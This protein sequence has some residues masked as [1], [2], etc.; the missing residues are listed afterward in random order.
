MKEFLLNLVHSRKFMITASAVVIVAVGAGIGYFAWSTTHPKTEVATKEVK[1]EE[2][3]S[4][5]EV[6]TF[7]DCSIE[8]ESIEKDL[9]LT[10]KDAAGEVVT[11]VDYEVK[12]VSSEL[13]DEINDAVAAIAEVDAKITEATAAADGTTE[14]G[15]EDAAGG[16]DAASVGGSVTTRKVVASGVMTVSAASNT[17]DAATKASESTDATTE[18]KATDAAGETKKADDASEEVSSITGEPLTELEE[19]AIEKQEAIDAYK[20]VLDG[21]DA[22]TY[23][24]DDVDGTIY[25]EEID[26]GDYLACYI[27]TEDNDYSATNYAV[28]VNVKDHVE[29]VAVSN[30]KTVSAAAAGDTQSA[31]KNVPVEATPTNTVSYVESRTETK[32]AEYAQTTTPSVSAEVGSA[33]TTSSTDGSTVITLSQSA[34]LY[35]TVSGANTA[36]ITAS[37]SALPSG[38]S[39]SV[40]SNSPAVSV[41]PAGGDSYTIAAGDVASNSV[42]TISATTTAA[43]GNAVTATCSV[44]ITGADETITNASGQTLYTD[45]NGTVATYRN[46]NANSTYYVMTK[47]AETV[48]YGWQKIGN[49]QYYFDQNGNKVTGTQV[50]NGATYN[51]GSDGVLLT[52]GFGIDVSKWQGN[53][54]WSQASS[55]ISFAIIRVGF[56]GSSGNIAVDPKFERNISQA[57]ANGVRVGVYF[58]SMAQNEAQAVEEA[59]LAIQQVSKYGVSLPIYI[60][61]EDNSQKALST[62]QR[63]AIVLAFCRTVQNSGYSAGV[64][65]NKNW[66]TTKLT[67]SKYSGISIWCAQ[68]NTSCTY[69]GR[70]D[71]WQYSSKGS[72]PGISGNVDLN[73]SYF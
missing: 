21:I 59:S 43:D 49:Y 36:T 24:D 17:E 3:S 37:A 54:D 30:V 61:M 39:L 52:S 65:A 57:K 15:T 56:R 31:T 40:T 14:E 6:P 41:T 28:S 71:I 22:E 7:V 50:I 29:Y 42:A 10:M 8:G 58:Y 27:P 60:D 20:E 1:K 12:L 18:E 26:P 11:G 63:D 38:A 16:D 25:V 45:T 47:E 35:S 33:T 72:I 4:I 66:L 53:I 68:Y 44:S 32:A 55:A 69:S 5:V 73:Q 23:D 64:Y 62:D 9:T 19:L 2:N 51:F 48:Y 34:S 70:Y 13:A 46:Y 67:P